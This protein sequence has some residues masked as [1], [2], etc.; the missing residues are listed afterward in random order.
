MNGELPVDPVDHING[1]RSDNRITNLRIVTASLS[2]RNRAMSRNNT[3]GYT[4]IVI[5]KDKF[6]SVVKINRK[7]IYMGTFPTAEL[8]HQA[9]L[10]YFQAHPEL[11]FTGRHGL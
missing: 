8:A 5:K 2:C 4:G 7:R 1:D 11:G 10:A 3:T 6:V 9:R